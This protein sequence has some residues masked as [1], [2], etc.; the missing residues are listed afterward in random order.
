[1]VGAGVGVVV[2]QALGAGRRDS[3][4]ALAC[5]AL[6]A[7]TR[8]GGLTAALGLVGAA[9]LMQLLNAP[10][11]ASNYLALLFAGFENDLGPT[12]LALVE[13]LVSLGRAL[14]RQFV[15]NDPGRLDLV[16]LDQPA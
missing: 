2:T 3:A 12:L 11:E 1:M 14:K 13:F 8:V 7:S 5:A 4:H 15:R 10:A 16:M 6:G 9:P